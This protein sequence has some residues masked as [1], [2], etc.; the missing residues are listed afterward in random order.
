MAAASFFANAYN[1]HLYMKC[2]NDLFTIYFCFHNSLKPLI[3]N[4]FRMKAVYKQK[5]L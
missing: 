2:R 4:T 3:I 5:I 1:C